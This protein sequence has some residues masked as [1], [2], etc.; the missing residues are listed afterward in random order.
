MFIIHLDKM[1]KKIHNILTSTKSINDPFHRI[2]KT[3]NF[4]IVVHKCTI[5]MKIY[6]RHVQSYYTL[7]SFMFLYNLLLMYDFFFLILMQLATMLQFNSFQRVLNWYKQRDIHQRKSNQW[8]SDTKLACFLNNLHYTLVDMD[9]WSYS[10]KIRYKYMYTKIKSP[11][12]LKMYS[13]CCF[14]STT[15]WILREV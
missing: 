9:L 14:H 11:I 15:K 12:W 1:I 8:Q 2:Y 5:I 10:I 6:N 7:N 13:W 3:K 4:C